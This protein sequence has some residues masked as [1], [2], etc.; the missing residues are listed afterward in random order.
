MSDEKR[1]YVQAVDDMGDHF[2]TSSTD[3]L[4]ILYQVLDWTGFH[5]EILR[6][7]GD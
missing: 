2:A 7:K 6:G 1:Y 5:Y 4:E 3:P